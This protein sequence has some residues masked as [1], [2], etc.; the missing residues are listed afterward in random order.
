MWLS[1]NIISKMVDI[2]DLDPADIMNRL[3]MSTAEI[4]G[5]EYMNRH[6][7]SVI[8]VKRP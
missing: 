5:I 6:L 1:L 8:A 4:E 3:T 2:K 7:T